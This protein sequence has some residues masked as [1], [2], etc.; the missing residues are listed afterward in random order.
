[1]FLLENKLIHL[2]GIWSYEREINKPVVST[3]SGD[4]LCS[5]VIQVL[6]F[7]RTQNYILMTSGRDSFVL[8]FTWLHTIKIN[9][10]LIP[11]LVAYENISQKVANCCIVLRLCFTFCVLCCHRD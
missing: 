11:K 2:N 7:N 3:S 4:S 10:K 5:F 6:A 8:A 1:M 9:L